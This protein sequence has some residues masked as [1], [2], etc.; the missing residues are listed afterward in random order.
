MFWLKIL[1]RNCL[2]GLLLILVFSCQHSGSSTS[3]NLKDT[4]A[5]ESGVAENR[6]SPTDKL[7]ST[8]E[9]KSLPQASEPGSNTSGDTSQLYSYE[10]KE[11]YGYRILLPELSYYDGPLVK[12]GDIF[13]GVFKSNDGMEMEVFKLRK[14]QLKD[15]VEGVTT[16]FSI[17]ENDSHAV[18]Y[19]SGFEPKASEIFGKTFEDGFIFPGQ[20][21]DVVLPR[22]RYVIYADGT[23]QRKDYSE[24]TPLFAGI[25]NYELRVRTFE[26]NM[27]ISDMA[28]VSKYDIQYYDNVWSN[29]EIETFI[30]WAGDIDGDGRLDLL[31]GDGIKSCSSV[32]LYL[33]SKAVKNNLF[34]AA[35]TLENCGC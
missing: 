2:H 9:Q 13:W 8:Y 12:P 20:I 11:D 33:S 27:F 28:L 7:K 14:V 6:D 19:F 29:D 10:P 15:S 23:Y 24:G 31:A 5:T 25:N 4:T 21:I 30:I 35:A 34:K 26:N 16:P 32:I 18:F 3:T 22:F 1:S 17:A